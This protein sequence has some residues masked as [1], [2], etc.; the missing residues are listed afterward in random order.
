MGKY[1]QEKLCFFQSESIWFIWWLA[2]EFKDGSYFWRIPAEAV[3][4]DGCDL[5]GQAV[6]HGNS[7]GEGYGFFSRPPG[8]PVVDVLGDG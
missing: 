6:G 8:S 3:G 1:P 4:C 5:D 2:I 7:T